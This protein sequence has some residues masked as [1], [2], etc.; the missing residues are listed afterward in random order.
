M[1]YFGIVSLLNGLCTLVI[2]I[3]VLTK[4]RKSPVHVSFSGFAVNVALW[5]LFYAAWQ[6]QTA[7]APALLFM[8]LLMLPTYYVPFS[9]LWFVVNL[10]ETERRDWCLAIALVVPSLFLLFGFSGLMVKD[11]APKLYFPYWP[12]PG[13]LMHGFV[14]IFFGVVCFAFWLL[15]RSWFA[16]SGI[17]RWQL[18]WVTVTTLFA[19]SGGATNWF[20]WYGVPIPP[21][22]NV[23]VALSFLVLA[24]AVIRRQ[25]LDVDT[26]ADIVQEARLSVMG[27]MAA[28]INHEI[29]NP[30]FVAKGLAESSLEKLK[31]RIF[32][33]MSLE[34]CDKML[35]EM[36]EKTVQ[37]ISRALEIMRRFSELSRPS[38]SP[39]VSEAVCL[40]EVVDNVLSFIGYELQIDKIKVEKQVS[41]ETVVRGNRKDIEEIFLNLMINAC[42]AMPNGGLLRI[43]DERQSEGIRIHVS[44]SGS[45]IPRDRIKRIFDPFYSGKGEKGSG[46]GL[47]IVKKL[48]ERNAGEII[49]ASQEGRGSTFTVELPGKAAK[50]MF[51]ESVKVSGLKVV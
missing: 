50:S 10:I 46:L 51:T 7:K 17:R 36:L 5:A 1:N 41:S 13:L 26:L 23:F 28:S 12:E 45:G 24:Y 32:N 35:E 39:G 21:I 44:D 15:F 33:Q 40:S 30:L 8:R 29:R 48:V 11:V 43:S 34:E 14:I 2:G 49:V 9:F 25:L 47:Y 4:N 22:P 37:Q 42:Q 18:R 31:K 3:Y 38:L 27:A 6:F 20:L 19:W 16:A